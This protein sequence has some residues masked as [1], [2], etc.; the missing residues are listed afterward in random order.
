[1]NTKLIKERKKFVQ[2]KIDHYQKVMRLTHYDIEICYCDIDDPD[3]A[4]IIYTDIQYLNAKIC[5][6]DSTLELD[7]K[8]IEDCIR[9][10]L[11]HII[12][13]P[14]QSFIRMNATPNEKFQ[15]TTN[16]EQCVEHFSRIIQYG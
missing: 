1:M 12:V 2:S 4:M 15:V 3:S 5:I 8:D 10:E 9:H 14:L 11:C 13:E 6:P 16:L 7:E